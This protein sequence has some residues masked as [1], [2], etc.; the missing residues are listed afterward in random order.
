MSIKSKLITA[1]T[2]LTIVPTVFLGALIFHEARSVLKAVRIS[3]LENIA[4]LKKNKIETFFLE[5]QTDVAAAQNILDIKMN[6]PILTRYAHDSANPAFQKASAKMD[7]QMQP[8]QAVYGYL[9]VMLANPEGRVVY[10][11]DRGHKT[12]INKPL[13]ISGAFE[14]G[15]K[16]IYFTDVFENRADHNRFEMVAAAPLY[17]AKDVFLG[18]LIIEIDMEPV[19]AFIRE[20]TGLGK[21]GEALIVKREGGAALFL[22]PLRN[23]P[24]AALRKSVAFNE[25]KAFP[26]QLAA[27]GKEGSGISIDYNGTQVLAA[28][29]YIPFVRW[30]LV[31]K[32][33]TAEAYAPV[34]ALKNVSIFFGVVIVI[35]GLTAALFIA[36]SFSRPISALQRGTEII[37][38]GDLEH[39]VGTNARDEVGQLSR[40]FDRMTE[41]LARINAELKQKAADLEAANKEL[42]SFSYSVSHDLRAPLRHMSGFVELLQKKTWEDMDETSR[43]YMA[44]IAAS[45]KRM[46]LLIDDLLTFSRIGRSEMRMRKVNTEKLVRDALTE[47]GPE[48]KDRD[49]AWEIGPLPEVFGDPSLLRLVLVNLIANAVK[50]TRV[51]AKALIEI[52]CTSDN[53]EHVFFIR[54][55]G[56]GFNMK[57]QE[58]LF[59]V[60]QRLHRQ[61]E[62]EGTGIGLANVRRIISRHSGRTWAEGA[63][64][65][66]A[67]FYF[68]LP[69]IK[70]AYNATET[71]PI[72]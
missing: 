41:S 9:D 2:V 26:A 42:E 55:N 33:T 28:W 61:E 17:D 40:A 58:K 21:T 57:Y 50:F 43:R 36:R 22:S 70:E 11:S 27:Q 1:F 67:T 35:L 29:R 66:G 53:D 38:G 71:Y 37:G 47:L 48:I 34:D 15:K 60:F 5:R 45:A 49:I 63:I 39:R 56:V 59:G 4:D 6:L 64:E 14:E 52:G 72:G 68:T 65:K 46:G 19:F 62:F 16:G 25:G 30:G 69:V 32:I 12:D 54:D 31:T 23:D 10:A 3:Q 44:T 24:S 8:L 7:V 13:P 20:T 18:E 51:R